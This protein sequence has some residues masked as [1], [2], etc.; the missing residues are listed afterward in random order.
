MGSLPNDGEGSVDDVGSGSGEGENLPGLPPLAPPLPPS[1]PM[2]PLVPAP[3]GFTTVS[4]MFQL[5][6]AL[7]AAQ[8][9]G[10]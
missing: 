2:P 8:P 4:T 9:H 7:D 5:R 10:A 3:S 6:A 1:P